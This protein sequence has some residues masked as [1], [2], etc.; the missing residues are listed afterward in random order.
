MIIDYLDGRPR[1]SFSADTNTHKK[2]KSGGIYKLLSLGECLRVAALT[3]ICDNYVLRFDRR[4]Y[5]GAMTWPDGASHSHIRRED[6]VKRLVVYIPHWSDMAG[7]LFDEF[8]AWLKS[9]EALFSSATTLMVSMCGRGQFTKL[10]KREKLISV[11][12]AT[13][14]ELA[15]SL[16]HSL[17]QLTPTAAGVI[18]SFSEC[19]DRYRMCNE[20]MSELCRGN[21]TR[22]LV[23][24]RT[25]RPLIA[26]RI[27]GVS[28][29]TRIIQGSNTHSSSFAH[30]AYANAS[31]LKDLSISSVTERQ[32]H[33]LIYGHKNI[34][35]VY[36]SLA[37]LT[38]EVVKTPRHKAWTAIN[39]E[40]SFPS[41]LT[42]DISGQYLFEDGLLYRG[43]GK[44]LMNL[45]VPPNALAKNLFSQFGILSRN[46]VTRMN[47][48]HIGRAIFY[49]QVSLPANMDAP[50]EQ[51]IRCILRVATTLC[52]YRSFLIRDNLLA[53]LCSAPTTAA[54]R[55]LTVEHQ[56][57]DLAGIL[58]VI[59]A[60]PSLVSIT[61]DIRGRV[62]RVDEIPESQQ[63]SAL[64]AKHY[65][66]SR[67]FRTLRALDTTDMITDQ[68]SIIAMQI[69]IVCPRFT[70]M[71]VCICIRSNFVQNVSLAMVDGPFQPYADSIRRLIE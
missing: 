3:R 65:P 7:I 20:L 59:A 15:V 48:I 8:V 30:V 4:G 39:D 63:P 44:T 43:N 11:A 28:G 31:T 50:I 5:E 55:H 66:L 24:S 53:A 62:E 33:I 56:F 6:L 17:L 1:K 57:F 23:E 41:L 32:W 12:A 2:R 36:E 35:V 13:D 52:I 14:K 61:S 49:G 42:L 40:V 9:K 21:V 69:A 67:N 10:P 45:C 46:G 70:F 51:Q 25:P 26:F 19:G 60:L 22:V 64:H 18:V 58:Q 47:S 38:M 37:R 16:G 68:L 71:D 27:L 34:P 54:L 29:L